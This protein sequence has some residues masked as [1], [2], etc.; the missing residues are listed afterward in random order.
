MATTDNF[1]GSQ[2]EKSKVKTLIV[3]DFFKA[4]F[5][6]INNSVGKDSSEIIYIDLFCG[7]GKFEDG[8]NSTPLALLDIVNNFKNEDIRKKLR[9]VFN[10][11]NTGF[12]ERLKK[13]VKEHEVLPKLTFQPTILNECA[14]NVDIKVHTYKECP[15]FSF[16]DPWGY[17][18]VSVT[19]TW[20]LVK[21]IG[22]DCVLFFNSN[23]FIMDINKETQHCHLE[24]IFGEQLPAV[25]DLVNNIEMDQKKKAERIV[26]L[27]SRNLMREMENEKYSGYKLFVLPFGFEADNKEK[28]SHHILFI[29]KSHKAIVE[30]KKVMLKHNNSNDTSLIYDSK[31]DFQI[32]LFNRD[33]F[34]EEGIMEVIKECMRKNTRFI[35]KTWKVG[36]LLESLDEC[37]MAEKYQVTPYLA[38][39]L[40]GV[41]DNLDK[42]GFVEVII[43]KGKKIKKRITNDREFKLKKELLVK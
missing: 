28:I 7:P 30:M 41:I 13:L 6:I 9:I 40:K 8:Q 38:D 21:N 17:K 43:P 11:E 31:D 14:K 2:S 25:I 23:R 22:S 20:E 12:V 32:S 37:N 10:D 39:E 1:F 34:V 19:Q 27:F 5:P 4:Y 16:I 42:E 35:Y 15:I 3:T 18:D 29:T 36:T 26:E 33:D 24:P